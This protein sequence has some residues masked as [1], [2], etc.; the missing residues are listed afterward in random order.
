[1]RFVRALRRL[2]A[3]VTP[4]LTS[5]G[6]QFTT[7]SALAWAAG[8][9]ART[10]FAGEHTH[11]AT[12][13]A[14]I[15]APASASFLARL[16]HGLTDTPSGALA[17]SYLGAGR[18]VLVVPNMHDSLAAAPT[19]RRNVDL[20]AGL[21]V[22][23]LGARAEEGKQKFPEPRTL[24]DEVAHRLNAHARAG[25]SVVVTFGSTRGYIDDVR[26]VSNYSS[27]ALGS[28]V[29]E[30]LYRL[31]FGVTAVEGACEIKPRVASERV[32][33]DTNEAMQAAAQAAVRGGAVAAVLAASVLDFV[34]S[35]RQRGKIPTASNAQVPLTLARTEKIIAA[36]NPPSGVKVGFKLETG[37]TP[38]RAAE[39]ARDYLAKYG[40]SL[41]VLNDLADVDATR[42]RA[43]LFGPGQTAPREIVGKAAVARAIAEHVAGAV[44]AKAGP[45]RA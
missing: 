32:K 1:V 22:S 14:L 27:G 18:P 23:F 29:C 37:L 41:I 28:G 5:G 39:I 6:A 34:P 16:A 24:A 33:A 21:G 38:A 12:G 10:A 31:G 4:W 20:L 45:G 42:H 9:P 15:A 8:K 40:L 19:V 25:Q 44:T 35:E 30:E 7:E 43:L 36:V 17:A 2:G 3:D 26:Y 11:L 13:D